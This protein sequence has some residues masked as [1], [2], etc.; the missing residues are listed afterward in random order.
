MIKEELEIMG[1][2]RLRDVEKAQQTI[3]ETAKLLENEG[4][5]VIPKKGEEEVFV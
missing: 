3:I 1:P 4:K 5:L 2:V